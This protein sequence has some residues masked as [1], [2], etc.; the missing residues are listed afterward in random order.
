MPSHLCK[1]NQRLHNLDAQVVQIGL[2]HWDPHLTP[3]SGDK[4]EVARQLTL[5]TYPRDPRQFLATLNLWLSQ[6]GF[7]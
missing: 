1:G 2:G 5:G 4:L 6:S 3:A 7:G